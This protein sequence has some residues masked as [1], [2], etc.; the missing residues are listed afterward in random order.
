MRN[1]APNPARYPQ[2]FSGARFKVLFSVRSSPLS[3]R[4]ARNSEHRIRCE[5]SGQQKKRKRLEERRT[6]Q[7]LVLLTICHLNLIVGSPNRTQVRRT[8]MSVITFLAFT[9][10]SPTL[11]GVAPN[12]WRKNS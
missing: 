2:T 11:N 1:Q 12:N 5:T 8:S 9:A 10:A 3:A 7:C 6:K 4:E